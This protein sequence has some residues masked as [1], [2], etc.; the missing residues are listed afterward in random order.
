MTSDEPGA[1]P[2]TLRPVGSAAKLRAATG[3]PS[4]VNAFLAEHLQDNPETFGTVYDVIEHEVDEQ[5]DQSVRFQVW[6]RSDGDIIIYE[7]DHDAWLAYEEGNQALTD[8]VIAALG[9]AIYEASPAGEDDER[10]V[11]TGALTPEQQRAV[12][13]HRQTEYR[14]RRLTVPA[15]EEI[16]YQA[17]P[18]LDHGFVRV[19]DY[20][21]GDAAVVQAARVSYADGTRQVSDDR[22]L[23]RYLMRMQHGTPLEMAV[24]K[25]HVKLPIFVARQWIRHRTASV[26]EI[27][28]RYSIIRDEFY[29]PE[30]SA[31]AAQSRSNRQGRGAQFSDPD[32]ELVR[33]RMGRHAE[34]SYQLYKDLLQEAQEQEGTDREAPGL[35]R[36]LARMVLPSSLYTEWFWQIDLRN[37][38]HFLQ[39][40]CDEHAQYEIRVYAEIIRDEILRRWTP[41]VYDAFNDYQME[42]ASLSRGALTL[43]REMVSGRRG[44]AEELREASGIAAREW[45]ET[46]A[47]LG[48]DE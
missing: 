33:A 31:V 4:V 14:T 32:A 23:I 36:E 44:E 42:A 41:L 7:G 39:L 24:V 29:V 27:S 18:V 16:L 11:N 40:R 35:A 20:H 34:E 9:D 47:L 46:M 21:G 26:N 5:E 17:F 8:Q 19:V 48:L 25:L 2:L 45:R 10:R 28:A 3:E 30:P 37:L 22:G 43:V 15:V 13:E 12:I 1:G 38:L 6:N